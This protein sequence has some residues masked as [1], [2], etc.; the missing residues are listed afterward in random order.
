M[1]VTGNLKSILDN[2]QAKVDEVA[3]K[4][5]EAER[6]ATALMFSQMLEF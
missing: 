3:F 6:A 4:Q 1:F 2:H 5:V